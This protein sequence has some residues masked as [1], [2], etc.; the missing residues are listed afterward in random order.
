MNKKRKLLV[1]LC[2][3]PSTGKTILAKAL[4]KKIDAV[5]LSTD[6]IRKDL[7]PKP[8]YTAKEKILV[9]EKMF[10]K[11]DN[12]LRIGESV[13]LDATFFKEFL[14]K[15]AQGI[16]EKNNAKFILI[17]TKCREETVKRF[18]ER[19]ITHKTLSDADYNVYKMLKAEFEPVKERHLVINCEEET[20]AK[21]GAVL[22]WIKKEL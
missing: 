2:G 8:Q 21:I 4:S 1:I 12:L 18:F 11:A 17:E 10:E 20:E 14:R 3:L 7:F 19:R 13:I 9:Y 16:A 5:H 22:E 15:K 6:A